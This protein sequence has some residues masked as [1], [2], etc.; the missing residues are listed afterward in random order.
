MENAKISIAVVGLG[1][2][3]ISHLAALARD[4]RFAV[5]AVCDQAAAARRAAG[6][7]VFKSLPEL[8]L[9]LRRNLHVLVEKPF[10]LAA[11][12]AQRLLAKAASAERVLMVGPHM[13]YDDR[14]RK[15]RTI[16]ESQEL[17]KISKVNAY[18]SHDWGGRKPPTWFLD[19]AKSGGGTIVDNTTHFLALF[20]LLL[21]SVAT[22]Q[23]TASAARYRTVEDTAI[24]S[25]SFA[26]GVVGAIETSWIDPLG[27]RSGLR[28][29][30]AKAVLEMA[31]SNLGSV[32]TVSRYREDG[33][34]NRA[35]TEQ[36]YAP[37]GIERR[38]PL[39]AH[40]EVTALGSMLAAFAD[41]INRRQFERQHDLGNP[42][43]VVQLVEACYRSLR[44]G[45]SVRV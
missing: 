25:L 9:A 38:R 33:A 17:G 29:A 6:V 16:I 8:D 27:R 23:V 40:G 21:G 1:Q 28:I 4:P 11:S 44:L 19:S 3:G 7:S 34:Y 35:V 15:I 26:S 10:V 45:R 14:I 5:A 13:L 12:R 32:L 39:Q 20:E 41:R 43:R 22:V 30:G 31:D 18:Q 2:R 24:I 42:L 36:V 37:V